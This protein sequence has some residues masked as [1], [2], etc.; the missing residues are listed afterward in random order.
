MISKSV[1]KL[2]IAFILS[3]F[4]VML[5]ASNVAFSADEMQPAKKVV[6]QV[7]SD[8][9]RTQNIAMNNAVN[10]QKLYGVDNI[11]I[12]IV[13]YGPGL[14]MLTAAN[15]QTDRVKSLAMQNITF[16]ACGNTMKKVAKKTGKEPKLTEGVKVVEAGVARIIELQDSG[17]AYVRP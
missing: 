11:A 4:L 17:Y 6:I 13:A 15:K 16:S 10:L 2:S 3:S 5:A 14:G 12:E 7:S 8:D 1:S 9:A